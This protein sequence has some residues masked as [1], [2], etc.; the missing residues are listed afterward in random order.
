MVD[1]KTNMA[2]IKTLKEGL[3]ATRRRPQPMA[4]LVD[5]GLI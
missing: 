4:W 1:P 3:L 2:A 5:P